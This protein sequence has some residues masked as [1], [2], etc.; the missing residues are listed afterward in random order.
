MYHVSLEQGRRK[1]DGREDKRNLRRLARIR[2]FADSAPPPAPQAAKTRSAVG[3]A[4]LASWT[5]V[6]SIRSSDV[7]SHSAPRQRR[8]AGRD[9][10]DVTAERNIGMRTKRQADPALRTTTQAS[11]AQAR[12]V[13]EPRIT[14]AVRGMPM[15]KDR[16]PET[17]DRDDCR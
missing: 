14:P 13:M 16:K 10:D 17:R 4:R 7:M 1:G 6:R 9:H 15:E 11:F 5:E 2:M 8:G 12:S 3:V